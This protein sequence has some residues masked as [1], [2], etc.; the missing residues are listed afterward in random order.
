MDTWLVRRVP[1]TCQWGR[2][3]VAVEADASS[4][5]VDAVFWGCHHPIRAPRLQLTRCGECETCRYW[6]PSSRFAV[7][8]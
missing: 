6:E 4:S 7:P 3:G 1:W 2:F 5:K 8:C